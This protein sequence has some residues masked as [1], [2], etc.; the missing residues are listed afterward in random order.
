MERV[1]AT[2]A[3][4][5]LERPAQRSVLLD[6]LDEVPAA[7]GLK[8]ALA[9]EQLQWASRL[10]N[11]NSAGVS[12]STGAVVMSK[13]E[14]DRL[15]ADQRE[16]VSSTG[17][18]AA[19]ALTAKIRKADDDALGRLKKKMTVHDPSDAEKAEWKKVF[20]K[21]CSNLKAAIPGDAL[22]KIGAC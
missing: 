7:R 3:A 4:D 16:I 19:E 8:P 2:D 20:K 22:G 6:G 14:L 12:Y 9:A 11:L 21:A 10:T 5:P 13:K 15:S 1:A 17:K 18:Q